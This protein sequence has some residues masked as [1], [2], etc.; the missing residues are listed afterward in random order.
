MMDFLL[1]GLRRGVRRPMPKLYRGMPRLTRR[2]T[3]VAL[4]VTAGVP[5]MVVGKVRSHTTPEGYRAL[6]YKQT[7]D[8][9]RALVEDTSGFDAWL[10]GAL[11]GDSSSYRARYDLRGTGIA[12]TFPELVQMTAKDHGVRAEVEQ[13]RGVYTVIFL[14][15]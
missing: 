2:T 14:P 15:G 6:R 1:P 10:G 4:S 3:Q 13:V 5:T 11:V 7:D 9:L 8:D 12:K